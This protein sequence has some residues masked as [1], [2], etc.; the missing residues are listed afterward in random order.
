VDWARI[1][2]ATARAA[3][4]VVA[5]Y[6]GAN[7]L[8]A[9]SAYLAGLALPFDPGPLLA[10]LHAVSI[11]AALIVRLSWIIILYTA[12]WALI[13]GAPTP[14]AYALAVAALASL[15]ST[16][17]RGIR[18]WYRESARRLPLVFLTPFTVYL[19]AAGLLAGA[20]YRL[21]LAL[22]EPPTLPGE[23]GTVNSLL[24]PTLLYRVLVGGL[25]LGVAYKAVAAVA[26]LGSA[27]LSSPRMARAI[28]DYEAQEEAKPLLLFQ[29]RQYPFLEW[30]VVAFMSLL[31][32]PILYRPLAEWIAAAAGERLPGAYAALLSLAVTLLLSWAFLR[33]VAQ[34]LARQATLEYLLKP[35]PAVPI[36]AGSI[37]VVGILV[38]ALAA[39]YDPL[40]LLNQVVTGAPAD[41]DPF[42]G[43][44][45]YTPPEDYYRSLAQLIDLFARLLWGG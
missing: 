34:G 11:V 14:L 5:L 24:Y 22:E 29:G 40:T 27:A 38:I 37:V 45:D 20:A 25:V 10:I 16:P 26:E 42:A 12:V 39:G 21:V 35:R 43:L 4:T 44:L 15:A 18:G 6:A 9:L 19:I 28:L 1:A 2:R 32:A 41:G 17:L 36:V 3:Y 8:T 13:A 31:A 7:T 23:L 30:G 33:F